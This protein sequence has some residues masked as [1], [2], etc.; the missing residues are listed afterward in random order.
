[1]NFHKSLFTSIINLSHRSTNGFVTCLQSFE[2]VIEK[3]TSVCK[4]QRKFLKLSERSDKIIFLENRH[5]VDAGD[6]R[7][8]GVY[9]KK[10]LARVSDFNAKYRIACLRDCLQNRDSVLLY[11]N[12]FNALH[13]LEQEVI[14]CTRVA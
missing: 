2:S 10:K 7:T 6:A 1:M 9:I 13:K 12:L 14:V 4:A 3:F 8:R 11:T 5:A